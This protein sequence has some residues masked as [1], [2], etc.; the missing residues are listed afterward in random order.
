MAVT[1]ELNQQGFAGLSGGVALNLTAHT[2][3]EGTVDFKTSGRHVVIISPQLPNLR[4]V[5]HV[6]EM[7]LNAAFPKSNVDGGKGVFPSLRYTQSPVN[8]RYSVGL[9]S[10]PLSATLT[11]Y[12]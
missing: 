10:K 12:P 11:G 9:C 7:S 4:G 1:I 6:W 2:P 5:V 3:Q 8:L